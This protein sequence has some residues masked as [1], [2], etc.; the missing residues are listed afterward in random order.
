MPNWCYTEIRIVSDDSKGMENLYKEVQEWTSKNFM[1]NGFGLN[2]LGNIVGN[3]GIG[4]ID[5]GE[6]TDFSCRGELLGMS[7]SASNSRKDV[8][9]ISTNTAWEPM[10]GMWYMLADKYLCESEIYYTA[11]EPGCGIFITNEPEL[12]GNYYIDAGDYLEDYYNS[13]STRE[14]V[15]EVLQKILKTDE[16]NFNAL[17]EELDESDFS[18]CIGIH[19]WEYV[20]GDTLK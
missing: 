1:P 11:E 9:Y 2:W 16:S 5:T 14:E 10:L 18:E 20:H 12:S 13:C 15:I 19:R 6:P 7:I 8:L 17:I 4:T 3:S